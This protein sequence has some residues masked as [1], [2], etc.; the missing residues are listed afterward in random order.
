MEGQENSTC[1]QRKVVPFAVTFV[2]GLQLRNRQISQVEEDSWST[3]SLS[4]SSAHR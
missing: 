3:V 4:R 2:L 1:I